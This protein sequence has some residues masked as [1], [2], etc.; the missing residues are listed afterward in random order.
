MRK[1]GRFG[2]GKGVTDEVSKTRES[3][4][5]RLF[6]TDLTISAGNLSE[7]CG[8]FKNKY[9]YIPSEENPC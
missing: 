8:R 7:M 9:I 1:T 6:K 4:C 2:S 5:D 3:L